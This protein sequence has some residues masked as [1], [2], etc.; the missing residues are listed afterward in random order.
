MRTFWTLL[1]GASLP[2]LAHAAVFSVTNLAD[3]GPGSLR[4]AL[5]DARANPGTDTITL[6]VTLSGTCTMSAALAIDHSVAINGPGADRVTLTTNQTARIFDITAGAVQ[7]RGLSIVAGRAPGGTGSSGGGILC[8]GSADVSLSDCTISN[9]AAQGVTAGQ[10]GGVAAIGGNLTLQRCLV[11]GNGCSAATAAFGGGLSFQSPGT[12]TLQS[13]TFLGNAAAAGTVASGAGLAVNN[14]TAMIIKCTFTE[15]QL[16]NAV[17]SQGGAILVGSNATTTIRHCT[18]SGNSAL[19]SAGGV[20]AQ[21]STL[22]S[23][24][25]LVANAGG[26]FLGAV[27]SQGH[28][29]NS[30]GSGGWIN[31]VNGD[32]VGSPGNP[33]DA[34]LGPLARNGGPVPTLRL[35]TGSPAI[36][37]GA[38]SDNQTTDQ[39]GAIREFD[40]DCSGVATAD[41]G[42][43]EYGALPGLGLGSSG[44]F[45]ESPHAPAQNLS[46]GFTI[47]AWVSAESFADPTQTTR[48][49]SNRNATNS[50]FG[51]GQINGKLLFTTYGRRDYIAEDALLPLFQRVHVAVVF[52]A[53]FDAYFYINGSP[54]DVVAGTLPAVQTPP[55]VP[56]IIGANTILHP[57]TWRGVIEE[58]RLWDEPLS[59]PQISQNSAAVL[60]GDESGLVG[61]WRFREGQ[62]GTTLEEVF[63]GS[64]VIRG[65]PTWLSAA[66]AAEPCPGDAD[67][68]GSVGLSDLAAQ[69]AAFGMT[70]GAGIENGD[71]DG[72]G[73]VDLG[74]LAVLLAAFGSSCP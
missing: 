22:I 70:G 40:G 65:S 37:A 57:Q 73:D 36:D 13:C 48:I 3:S 72:D 19:G 46:A 49:I 23:S 30:D 15:N 31:G 26:N 52:D 2:A 54:V 35:L 58:V 9:C 60:S 25:L 29:L 1:A 8:S 38:N 12:L 7:I 24:S 39:R 5:A 74:D 27:T 59:G 56:M 47:E 10:G 34:L 61:L 63:G 33:L 4:Q 21:G 64:A 42:A 11:Q 14:G 67:G 68:D 28:N 45:V 20:L 66:C 41:I 50:G 69:L 43:F 32:L 16:G 55:G 51:F 44:Q 6:D 17:S 53:A 18:I 62:G 71:F